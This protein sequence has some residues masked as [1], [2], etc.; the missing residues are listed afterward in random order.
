MGH[1]K[2]EM[3]MITIHEDCVCFAV[4]LVFFFERQR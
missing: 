1:M 3:C 4:F 2:R